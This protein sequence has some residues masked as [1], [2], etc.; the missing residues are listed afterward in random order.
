M[1][2]SRIH[3]GLLGAKEAEMSVTAMRLLESGSREIFHELD[4]QHV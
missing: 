2:E 3:F 1:S 4:V